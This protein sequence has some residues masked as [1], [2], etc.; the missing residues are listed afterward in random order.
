MTNGA[1]TGW[2]EEL[3][4]KLEGIDREIADVEVKLQRLRSMRQGL[5]Q[6]IE[7]AR[8]EARPGHSSFHAR[9]DGP[10]SNGRKL[11]ARECL[12]RVLRGAG[13]PLAW[14]EVQLRVAEFS[15]PPTPGALTSAFYHNTK[16]G[17]RTFLALGRGYAGLVGR[18]EDW[19]PED[20]RRT[21]LDVETASA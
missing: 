18:D 20:G 5:S 14:H 11:P 2:V 16:G 1:D 15:H 9:P 12:I 6:L 13:R 19:E 10:M 21:S 17:S 4:P 7:A 3:T 8:D